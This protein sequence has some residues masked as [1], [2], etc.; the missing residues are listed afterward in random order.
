MFEDTKEMEK[1]GMSVWEFKLENMLCYAS[2]AFGASRSCS[3]S[4][5]KAFC[6]DEEAL[7]FELL[8]FR[9]SRASIEVR[10]GRKVQ[11]LKLMLRQAKYRQDE[12]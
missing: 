7:R 10:R 11:C 6:S 8:H 9:Y 3:V 4:K 2:S 1:S 5:V 12:Y